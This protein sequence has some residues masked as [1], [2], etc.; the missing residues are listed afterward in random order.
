M[1]NPETYIERRCA[2]W[3]RA[4][5]TRDGTHRGVVVTL[6]ERWVFLPVDGGDGVYITSTSYP[7]D[8]IHTLD[9]CVI[10]PDH[11]DGFL[12]GFGLEAG[13]DED[14]VPDVDTGDDPRVSLED[15]T[16]SYEDLNPAERFALVAQVAQFALSMANDPRWRGA[17]AA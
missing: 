8:G 7:K 2:V 14:D 11:V 16:V 5:D 4:P 10:S 13:L 9:A 3:H 15:L 6:P 1:D 17:G 12:H